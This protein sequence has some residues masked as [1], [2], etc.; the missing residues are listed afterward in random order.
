MGLPLVRTIGIGCE[1]VRFR[2]LPN[3]LNHG[4]RDGS[5]HLALVY[6]G[7]EMAI[8]Q[9]SGVKPMRMP[10]LCFVL[11]SHNDI[12][13]IGA[14]PVVVLLIRSMRRSPVCGGEGPDCFQFI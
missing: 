10:F 13:Q 3:V 11:A 2:I 4:I 12:T 6:L 5:G 1:E 7:H 9:P 14:S 8:L